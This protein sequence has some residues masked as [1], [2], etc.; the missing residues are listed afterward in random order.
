MLYPKMKAVGKA[1]KEVSAVIKKIRYSSDDEWLA[2]D[3]ERA[4]EM[5]VGISSYFTAKLPGWL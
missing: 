2:V 1:V 4:N 3:I 5:L